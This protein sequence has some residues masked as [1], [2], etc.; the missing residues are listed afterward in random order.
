MQLL[1]EYWNLTHDLLIASPTLY[2][3]FQKQ[4]RQ[5]EAMYYFQRYLFFSN[6]ADYVYG[7]LCI[8]KPTDA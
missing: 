7:K 5:K 1:L 4:M 6:V 8:W 2:P 3:L